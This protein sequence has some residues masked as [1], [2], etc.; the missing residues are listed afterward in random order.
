MDQIEFGNLE[1]QEKYTPIYLKRQIVVHYI[2]NWEVNELLKD[3]VIHQIRNMYGTG[4][5]GVG[6]FSVVSYF[7]H[8]LQD[9]Q[10]GDSIMIMLLASMWGLRITV[11][12]GDTGNQIKYRHSKGLKDICV[13]L[14]YNGKEEGGGHYSGLMRVDG[15]Y[16]AATPLKIS[17]N[18]DLE[19]DERERQIRGET[20]SQGANILISKARFLELCK[21]EKLL[22]EISAACRGEGNLGRTGARGGGRKSRNMESRIVT[23]TEEEMEMP[24]PD[25]IPV[26]QEGNTTC[27]H[28][29]V[30]CKTTKNLKTHIKKFHKGQVKFVCAT[31]NKGFVSQEG[32]NMHEKGHDEANV[33]KCTECDTTCSSNRALKR[34]MKVFHTEKEEFLCPYCNHKPFNTK[35][36]LE[37]HTKRCDPNVKPMVC[38]ICKKGK[39]YSPGELMQHKKRKHAW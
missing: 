22:G 30:D 15:Q 13:G 8:I 18:F 39:F 12:R 9:K 38:D 7:N 24:E 34:H 3:W 23:D 1:L 31:C 35:Y 16:L 6:P 37:Q 2:L 21:K 17:D 10:W 5:G 14:M 25:D 27:T 26:V 33:K 4:E 29:S 19:V 20:S 36:N 28:C 11:V 32:R